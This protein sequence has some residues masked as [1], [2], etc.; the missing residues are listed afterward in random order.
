MS[1]NKFILHFP[2]ENKGI[3]FPI[4]L[5]KDLVNT[6]MIYF[7]LKFLPL[8]IIGLFF[9]S[10]IDVFSSIFGQYKFSYNTH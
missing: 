2:E 4:C 9:C 8:N 10:N 5:M 3:E 7:L 6:I 1:N